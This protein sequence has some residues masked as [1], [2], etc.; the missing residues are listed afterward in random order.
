LAKTYKNLNRVGTIIGQ[1][2]IYDIMR[3]IEAIV[4]IGNLLE[5]GIVKITYA[6]CEAKAAQWI[7]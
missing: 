1:K 2:V 5:F 6:S 4:I 7:Q 3:G